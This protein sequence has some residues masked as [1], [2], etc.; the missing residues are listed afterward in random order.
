MEWVAL[1]SLATAAGSAATAVAVW[2]TRRQLRLSQQQ[3]R[4]GFE[5]QLEREYR[6]IIA[7]LPVGAL[8]GQPLHRPVAEEVLGVFYRY[9]DLTNQQVFLRSQ[10]RISDATWASWREGIAHQLR[11]PAFE[12]A[13]AQIRDAVPKDFR[14]LQWLEE[15][16][17]SGDPRGWLEPSASHAGDPSPGP[18]ARPEAA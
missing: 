12:A 16:G 4:S 14:E 11:R 15:T 5:D 17:F 10:D 9:I 3:A 7:Q 6:Q 18:R 8:L 1:G 13:W 2:F